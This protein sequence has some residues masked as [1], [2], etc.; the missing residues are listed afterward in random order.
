MPL[1]PILNRSA[2]DPCCHLVPRGEYP[3]SDFGTMQILDAAAMVSLINRFKAGAAEPGFA[4]VL[5]IRIISPTARE[6]VWLVN[7]NR[8]LVFTALR[9]GSDHTFKL[10]TLILSS[11]LSLAK[12]DPKT[13]TL[14][15]SCP[16]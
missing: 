6:E 5:I 3:H 2:A 4:G 11:D 12:A 10:T 13:A 1:I 16:V 8:L 14:V 9:D 15:L 7:V